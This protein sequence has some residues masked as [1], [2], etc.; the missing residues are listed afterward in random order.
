MMGLRALAKPTLKLDLSFG[1][2]PKD[3]A[4]IR[5]KGFDPLRRPWPFKAGSVAEAYSAY[6]FGRIPA[7]ERGP[8][9]DELHRV[10]MPGGKATFIVPY[11]S[12]ARSIQDPTVEWPPLSEQSFLYFNKKF[13]E[14]NKLDYGIACD[15]DFVYGYTFDPDTANRPDET[16]A[17][18]VKH[19]ANAVADLQLVLT[20]R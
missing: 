2:L 20:R 1:E 16:R 10:L 9:M 17:F 15:F 6:L 18:W 4:F 8:F 13:R 3:H 19:Y 12:S 7:R 14:D 11:W 5:P